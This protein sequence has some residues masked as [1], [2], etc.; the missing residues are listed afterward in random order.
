MKRL[1]LLLFVFA[2]ASAALRAGPEAL[3]VPPAETV[4]AGREI[5]LKVYL[6]N[7][8]PETVTYALPASIRAVIAGAAEP[9]TLPVAV[10]DAAGGA[11]TLAPMS[12]VVVDLAVKLPE[13]MSGTVSLRL[14]DPRSNTVM[15]RVAPVV[16]RAAVPAAAPAPVA[17]AAAPANL[18]LTSENEDLRRHLFAYEPIYFA[19][20]TRQGTNAKFQFSFKY[21]MFSAAGNVP[22]W[23]RDLYFSYTQTSLWDLHSLSKPFYDTSYK[24][25]FFYWRESFAA[26]PDWIDRLG[27]QAGLQHESNGKAGGD[28]RSLNTV[29]LT[30]VLGWTIA[31]QWKLVFGPRLIGYLEDE[32]NRDVTRYRGHVE[33]MARIGQ[34]KGFQLT[35]TWRPGSGSQFGAGSLELDAT[36]PLNRIPGFSP[37]IGGYVLA[38]WFT[39]YG[40]S[41]LGFDRR[42]ADQLRLG[43]MI[44]R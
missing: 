16:A 32:E 3:L 1:A 29:Y 19:V 27:L 41:L 2:A 23:W 22:S 40:E 44:V 28:S 33:V 14:L 10:V 13:E 20:G 24:P 26:H 34:E 18:E 42:G 39:G 7:P 6:N 21:R 31:R 38:Q 35:G 25:S 37:A 12:F 36:W 17:P 8:S 4:P 30:P 43:L 15:F 11:V 5:V 9:Q